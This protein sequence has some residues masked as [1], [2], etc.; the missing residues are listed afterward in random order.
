MKSIATYLTEL[1][2][3]LAAAVRAD[4]PLYLGIAAYTLA[5]LAF[6]SYAGAEDQATYA[7]YVVKWLVLFGIM[8]PMI[9]LACDYALMAH[10][11]SGRRKLA[12]ARLFSPRRMARLLAGI[13]LLL[14]MIAFQGTFTSVK[15]ALAVFQGGFPHDA[16]QADLDALLHFGIDP[17]RWLY[18]V[19]QHE[20][21]RSAV[22]WNYNVLWF[23][24]CFSSLF[25]V[26][27]SSRTAAL[28][29]RYLVVFMLVW[30][31]VGNL[32][33]GVFLSAGPA[34]YGLVT[35]DTQRFADQLGFLA[36]ST[37]AAHS[38]TAY[39]Q[40]LW[41][42]YASGRSGFGSGISAFPSIHVALIAMNAMFVWEYN[43]RLGIAAFA[44]VAFVAA[45][46]V[47]LAWHYAIDGYAAIAITFAIYAVVRRFLPDRVPSR[48]P[49][50]GREAE[51]YPTGP[52]TPSTV[53]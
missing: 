32:F 36:Q 20:I 18:A 45:S 25:F 26:V 27:T 12:A 53:S 23:V 51:G 43:R 17:W 35:G 48:R 31:V 13:A 1:G 2:S 39:Q 22:E 7:I 10:R 37:A 4:S 30:I 16:A 28:R 52:I 41:D 19:G 46:S 38:A 5:G 33:A 50:A 8:M 49:A 11:F 14:S 42:L 3:E 47:Y 40:Y 34:F 6:L 44:Y 21:V 15:N 29:T 24:I 9:S